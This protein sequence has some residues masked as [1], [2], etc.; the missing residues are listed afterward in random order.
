MFRLT[1]LMKSSPI[2]F[3]VLLLSSCASTPTIE[4]GRMVLESYCNGKN[5]NWESCYTKA[6]KSCRKGY[7]LL[8]KDIKD[9]HE[10]IYK[11]YVSKIPN[12]HLPIYKLSKPGY[13]DSYFFLTDHS[14]GEKIFEIPECAKDLIK[15]SNLK[16]A[17]DGTN[18]KA[19]SDRNQY[20]YL[21]H[22]SR[23]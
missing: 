21:S 19:L 4:N 12:L 23:Q 13:E 15:N 2:L 17:I 6:K 16:V 10:S 7:K 18:S 22:K 20:L 1:K 8:N 9:N 11:N 3:C 5:N 14:I